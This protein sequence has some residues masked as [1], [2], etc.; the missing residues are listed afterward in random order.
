MLISLAARVDCCDNF[1]SMVFQSAFSIVFLRVVHV[2]VLF[3]CHVL[4][5]HGSS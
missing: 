4:S 2:F 1:D 3:S 5:E